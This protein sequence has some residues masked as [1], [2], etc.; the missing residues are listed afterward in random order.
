MSFTADKEEALFYQRLSELSE[1]CVSRYCPEFT[2]FLDGRQLRLARDFLASRDNVRIVSYGGFDGAERCVVGI[3]PSDIYSGCDEKELYEMFDIVGIEV[4]GSGFSTFSHRDVMG[5]VLALGVKREAMGDIYVPVDSRSAY[6][7]MTSV[8][9]GFV[10][11]SLESVSRDK[12]KCRLVKAHELPVPERRYSVISG[13][14]AS[15][16]LDCV[17]SLVT[18]TSRE[19]AKTMITSGLVNVNHIPETRT[20]TQLNAEDLLSVRGYG[21][22]KICELGDLT[23]KGRSRTVVH[24]MI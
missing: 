16:R 3:F 20:D 9:A 12:V 21:R 6:L 18:K 14:I 4:R 24:K 7:C 23:R 13:T 8:A 17:I 11:E 1:R 10:C 2:H 22:F 15:P 5:S 19:K